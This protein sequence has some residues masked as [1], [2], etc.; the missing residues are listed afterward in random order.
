MKD[1]I[2]LDFFGK[3]VLII[4]CPASG[5]TFLSNK[6]SRFTHNIIHTDD[7]LNLG[8]EVGM[9][10]AMDMAMFSVKPSIVEGVLGYR[11]LRKGIEL[12]S[13]FP[14]IVI[15]LLI[16][17]KRQE[18]TYA[19]ERDKN[20]LKYLKQFDETHLKILNEYHYEC[21]KEK[22]PEWIKYLNEY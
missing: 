13:Y 15:E 4:G 2:N 16:P 1:L 11:M 20:K 19:K 9:Y 18:K 5:K 7:Y 22:R 3:N 8:Y 21:P 17:Y 6:I 14:D 10:A 12:G